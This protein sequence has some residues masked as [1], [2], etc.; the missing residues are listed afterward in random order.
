MSIARTRMQQLKQSQQLQQQSSS[1]RVG[2]LSLIPSCLGISGH[3]SGSRQGHPRYTGARSAGRPWVARTQF[4]TAV[5]CRNT[6]NSICFCTIPFFFLFL[7]LFVFFSFLLVSSFR[8]SFLFLFSFQRFVRMFCISSQSHR[9]LFHSCTHD[10]PVALNLLVTHHFNATRA[11]VPCARGQSGISA[12]SLVGL[13]LDIGQC[14]S[15]P[16][17][18]LEPLFAARDPLCETHLFAYTCSIRL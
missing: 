1:Q 10:V 12:S 14:G 18:S 8:S 11:T 4:S 13:G 6:A 9:F 17:P 3:P 2:A 16:V 15:V 7:N 5:Q